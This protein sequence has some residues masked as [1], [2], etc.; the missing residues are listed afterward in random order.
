VGKRLGPTFVRIVHNLRHAVDYFPISVRM[1]VDRENFRQAEELLRIL[2]DEGLSDRLTVYPGQ[3]VGVD[4]GVASPSTTYRP[5][6][7]TNAECR[8]SPSPST[9]NRRV[10]PSRSAPVAWPGTWTGAD[11]QAQ[12]PTIL[13]SYLGV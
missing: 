3:I 10:S 7:F 4:D 11:G 13:A 1:N 2:H 8:S 6:C 5:P 12:R 9:P